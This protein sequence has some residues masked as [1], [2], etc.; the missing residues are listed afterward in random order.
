MW[1]SNAAF[2]T[3]PL[4]DVPTQ[5]TLLNQLFDSVHQRPT[6]LRVMPLSSV[7]ITPFVKLQTFDP[8]SRRS[9][10][11]LVTRSSMIRQSQSPASH[12]SDHPMSNLSE[13]PFLCC[14][15]PCQ[16]EKSVD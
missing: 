7:V 2:S 11:R 5:E 15:N 16:V 13:S 3:S 4:I 12:A 1:P 10:S 9:Y 8:L 6:I 14:R